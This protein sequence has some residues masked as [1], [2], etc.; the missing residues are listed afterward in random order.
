MV[1]RFWRY[2]DRGCGQREV[3]LAF[4][5]FATRRLRPRNFTAELKVEAFFSE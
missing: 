5:V 1:L 2:F 4:G 3:G